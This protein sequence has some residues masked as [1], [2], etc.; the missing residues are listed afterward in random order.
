[1]YQ[2][3]ASDFIGFRCAMSRIGNKADF[4]KVLRGYKISKYQKK[5]KNQF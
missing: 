1:M 3:K 4:K 5:Y 2:D